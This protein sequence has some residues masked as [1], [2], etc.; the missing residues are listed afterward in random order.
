M[1]YAVEFTR[2]ARDQF[3]DLPP[4]VGS[5]VLDRIELLALDPTTLGRPG[6]KAFDGHQVYQFWGTGEA[7]RWWITVAFHFSQD[8]RSLVIDGVV[9][10]RF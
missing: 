6:G 8:E 2:K 10:Q 9:I 1:S 7:N 3:D 5:H 4:V